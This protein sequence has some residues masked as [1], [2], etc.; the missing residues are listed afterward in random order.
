MK[1]SKSQDQ[2]P[3][4]VAKR[5]YMPSVSSDVLTCPPPLPLHGQNPE[6]LKWVTQ[7]RILC[8]ETAYSPSFQNI[9]SVKATHLIL[10]RTEIR[11]T[12]LPSPSLICFSIIRHGVE[13]HLGL[14]GD[15]RAHKRNLCVPYVWLQMENGNSEGHDRESAFCIEHRFGR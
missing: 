12:S 11:S 1:I 15:V 4:D 6:P 8:F 5:V 10:P 2:N 14:C 13:I 3:P 9:I 7:H